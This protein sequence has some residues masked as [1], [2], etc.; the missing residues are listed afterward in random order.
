M[1]GTLASVYLLGALDIT[2]L[3]ISDRVECCSLLQFLQAA[4]NATSTKGEMVSV[5]GLSKA[6]G[7]LGMRLVKRR[8]D[9]LDMKSPSATF[10]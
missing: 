3:C 4:I 10:L 6:L 9:W 8:L 7:G 1:T 5:F 2:S